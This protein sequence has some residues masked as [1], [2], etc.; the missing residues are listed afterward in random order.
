MVVMDENETLKKVHEE[1]DMVTTP[2][3]LPVAMAHC[4]NCTSDLNAWVG[5][6]KE[7]QQALGVPVDMNQLFSVLYNKALEGDVDC[8]GLMAY[9]YFSGESIT[10]FEE[11]RPLFVRTPDSKFTL[12]NF[13]RTH[14]YTSLGALKVSHN[15]VKPPPIP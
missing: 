6:F 9:N 3:G 14:L 2:D 5:I 7:F 10:G 8:G 15:P 13:M 1:I 12:A 4:N 11:G